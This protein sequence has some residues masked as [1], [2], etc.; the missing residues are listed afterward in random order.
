MK[1]TFHCYGHP[2]L[3][4]KHIRTIE[5]TKDS[6]LSLQGDCIL[7]IQADF[8][9]QELK[10]LHGKIHITVE[11]DG[12][13]DTFRAVVNPNFDS[14]HEI[15]FRKSLYPS[16]RTFGH[17]LNKGAKQL[18]RAIVKLMQQPSAIMTITI[19]ESRDLILL[20]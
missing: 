15:V 2:N 17:F 3:R 4:A 11:I 16:P 20:K 10:K 18:D 6:D 19:Q 9:K 13:S 14:D 1:Y 8:C 7:G 12:L 5:F